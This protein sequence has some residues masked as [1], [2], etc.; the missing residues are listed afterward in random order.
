MKR[1]TRYKTTHIIQTVTIP[2]CMMGTVMPRLYN[3]LHFRNARKFGKHRR[4]T[5]TLQGFEGN[6][7][8]DGSW[9]VQLTFHQYKGYT[10]HHDGYGVAVVLENPKAESFH[11]FR[12]LFR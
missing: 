12:K 4:G 10:V 6:H 5:L 9:V 1:K 11:D 7:Q 8:P 2:R 3:A